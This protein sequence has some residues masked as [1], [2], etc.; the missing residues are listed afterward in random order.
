VSG[1][2]VTGTLPIAINGIQGTLD[3]PFTAT[4]SGTTLTGKWTCA[5][6]TGGFTLTKQ[7]Q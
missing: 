2:G 4:T 6:C 7:V 1:V 3:F 5:N